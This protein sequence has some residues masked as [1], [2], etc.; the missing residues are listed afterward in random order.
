M[1]AYPSSTPRRVLPDSLAADGSDRARRRSEHLAD[2][3]VRPV[4][5]LLH[6]LDLSLDEAGLLE[7]LLEVLDIVENVFA[8][9]LVEDDEPLVLAQL[10]D[11][12]DLHSGDKIRGELRM[13]NLTLLHSFLKIMLSLSLYY[14]PS[15]IFNSL[16]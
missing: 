5:R 9:I 6:I 15:I 3:V 11:V 16:S 2:V 10:E 7:F 13:G 4:L 8:L 1:V 12:R 14:P